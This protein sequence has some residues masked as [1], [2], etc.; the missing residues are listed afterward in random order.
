MRN[1]KFNKICVLGLGLIGGSLASALRASGKV[2]TVYGVD[3]KE[4]SIEFALKNGVIDEGS[5][6][7]APGVTDA[8]VV[9]IAAY[10]GEIPGLVKDIIPHVKPGA[11]ITDVGSS[12]SKI[13]GSVEELLGDQV[14]FVGGHPIAGTEYSGVERSNPDL[15]RGKRCVLTPTSSTDEK[16]KNKIADLWKLIGAEVHIMDKDQHDKVFGYVSHLPHVVAYALVNT[17]LDREDRE[18]LLDF[19]GGGLRDYTRIAASSPE[20]WTEILS[21]NR[22]EVLEAIR[23]FKASLERLEVAI[24]EGSTEALSNELRKAVLLKKSL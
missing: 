7:F 10:V 13:V 11:V 6:D 12:K 17:I 4:S 22:D 2:T 18:T 20:M 3:L 1:M 16:A 5:T 19:A 14:H 24:R 9:V 23:E 8:E 15:F 21:S